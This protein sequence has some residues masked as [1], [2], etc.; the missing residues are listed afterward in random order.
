MDVISGGRRSCGRFFGGSCVLSRGEVGLVLAVRHVPAVDPF[1]EA[2]VAAPFDDPVRQLQARE[3]GWGRY[4][5]HMCSAV[6]ILTKC[7]LV[8]SRCPCC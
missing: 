2:E 7:E 1:E 8:L 5:G 3:P 6:A 4:S